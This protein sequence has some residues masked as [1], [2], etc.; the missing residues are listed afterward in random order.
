MNQN[1]QR[2]C[3]SFVLPTWEDEEEEEES[4]ALEAAVSA[5]PCFEF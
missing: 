1:E 2:N 3:H 4:W 5:Q